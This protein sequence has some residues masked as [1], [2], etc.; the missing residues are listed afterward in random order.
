MLKIVR[1]IKPY[2]T[3]NYARG[4]TNKFVD[5][6]KYDFSDVITLIELGELKNQNSLFGSIK[7]N[8][9]ID[10]EHK[11]P[12]SFLM[13]GKATLQ[14]L[15]MVPIRYKYG[16]IYFM[17]GLCIALIV[18]TV[19]FCVTYR[20]MMSDLG[21]LDGEYVDILFKTVMFI[22]ICAIPSYAIGILYGIIYGSL[23]PISIP[24]FYLDY[25][26]NKK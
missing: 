9:E 13:K 19:K 10:R 2:S 15:N 22:P 8:Q 11:F 4:R 1:K 24:C 25:K 23:W 26:N 3:R 6:S 14:R 7:T 16:Y 21:L 5:L 18:F 20:Y 17:I 12:I